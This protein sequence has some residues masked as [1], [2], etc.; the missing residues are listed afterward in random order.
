[1]IQW[2]AYA[3]L[4]AALIGAAAACVDGLLAAWHR[5]RRGVWISAI[6]ASCIVPLCLPFVV[7][8]RNEARP[9]APASATN[10]ASETPASGAPAESS[11]PERLDLALLSAWAAASAALA[12]ALLIAHRRTRT[13]LAGCRPGVIGGR[14]A[15]ISDDFGPAVVGILR[16]HIVVPS[17]TLTLDDAE[18]RLVVA[19][20]LEHASSGDPLL[21]LVGVFAVV[22][23][24][25]N[26]ALWWQLS[27]LRLAIEL[28]C[29]ARVVGRRR[30]GALAYGQLLVSVGERAR[31]T[32]HPVLA[33]S[34]SRSALAKRFD[35]LLVRSSVRPRRI[36]G[37]AA[38]GVG[39]MASIAFLP[40]PNV[41]AVLA[42]MRAEPAASRILADAA[43]GGTY[44]ATFSQSAAQPLA[45]PTSPASD[46]STRPVAARRRNSAATLAKVA[47]PPVSVVPS[48]ANRRLLDSMVVSQAKIL[49]MTSRRGGVMMASPVAGRG[50][51][52]TVA[53]VD[54]NRVIR[55]G[56]VGGGGRGGSV[57][58]RARPDSTPP[59]R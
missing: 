22:A 30:D 39:I 43:K 11:A 34:R 38:L 12:I 51:F 6:V 27:R 56:G 46:S 23:M 29:D 55:A 52:A 32:R 49:P 4:C 53:P 37:L 45:A 9:T 1:M 25:W 48:A 42:A 10:V 57:I 18:Q 44:K 58:M 5:A 33:M 36:L 50:G 2:M 19:H 24:P 21:A 16:H 40:P 14:H 31:A 35:A 13:S 26:P 28:D 41:N 17:W 7:S 59:A 54:S 47:L 8:L 3:A 15:L 20:E